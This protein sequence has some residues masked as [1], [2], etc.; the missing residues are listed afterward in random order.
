MVQA[1]GQLL[2]QQFVELDAAPGWWV[3]LQRVEACSGG[4]LQ[5]GDA[6]LERRRCSGAM[7]SD[8]SV[9]DRSAASSSRSTSL[10]SFVWGSP[11]VVGYTGVS[12]C[13]SASSPLNTR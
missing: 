5:V 7:M 12:D 4:G 2:G 11:A 13:G 1:H 6:L 8:G 9:S 3:R 10:R